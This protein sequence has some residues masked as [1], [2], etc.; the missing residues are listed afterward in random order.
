MGT[1]C[2]SAVDKPDKNPL[3]AHGM[4]LQLLTKETKAGGTRSG[5]IPPGRDGEGGGGVRPE[6]RK[7]PLLQFRSA[8][9]QN[10][11]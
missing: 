10:F 4:T 5:D 1:Y 6:S 3:L 11:K 8:A 7:A 2:V 9:F